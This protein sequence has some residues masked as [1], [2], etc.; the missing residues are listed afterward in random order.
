M[1]PGRAVF[2][3]P[4]ARPL[5][6]FRDDSTNFFLSPGMSRTNETSGEELIIEYK[7]RNLSLLLGERI[8]ET[9]EGI[10]YIKKF[11]LVQVFCC[12][13]EDVNPLTS[14]RGNA[15]NHLTKCRVDCLKVFYICNY[16]HCL[17]IR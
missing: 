14:T 9:L 5:N 16:M 1:I 3:S 12:M 10:R 8:A 7:N 11:T 2:F 6:L 15:C 4:S 17:E 13:Y